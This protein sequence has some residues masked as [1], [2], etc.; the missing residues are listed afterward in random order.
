MFSGYFIF[1]NE[2]WK[3]QSRLQPLIRLRHS[4]AV[5]LA[6]SNICISWW[7]KI[8]NKTKKPAFTQDKYSD[9]KMLKLLGDLVR[10]CILLKN[11]VGELGYPS[12]SL[13]SYLDLLIFFLLCLFLCVLRQGINIWSRLAW[14]SW[15]SCL[16]LWGSRSQHTCSLPCLL[17]VRLA[18]RKGNAA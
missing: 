3:C 4:P 8:Q 16:S 10:N 13:A 17:L 7:L 18:C 6:E 11:G 2:C 5:S 1:R 12:Q 15:L 9:F 14:N